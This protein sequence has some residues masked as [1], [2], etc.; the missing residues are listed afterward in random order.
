MIREMKA[1]TEH[2]QRDARLL[3]EKKA[4]KDFKTL[5]ALNAVALQARPDL[6]YELSGIRM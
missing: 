1:T 4:V 3:L 5:W 2:G 6:I